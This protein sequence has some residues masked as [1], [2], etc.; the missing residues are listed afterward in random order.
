MHRISPGR[1][2][3]PRS[4]NIFSGSGPRRKLLV[5]ARR[6]FNRSMGWKWDSSGGGTSVLSAI[7]EP[8]TYMVLAGFGALGLVARL[9]RFAAK[10]MV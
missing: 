3:P 2:S 10:T 4:T 5:L 6:L 8:S 1:D 7:P 9:K